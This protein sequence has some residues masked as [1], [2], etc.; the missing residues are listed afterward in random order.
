[1]AATY[2]IEIDVMKVCKI[3]M[4]PFTDYRNFIAKYS[5]TITIRANGTRTKFY[6]MEANLSY[7]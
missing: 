4:I 7:V 5:K 2:Y 3:I 1:M 6:L